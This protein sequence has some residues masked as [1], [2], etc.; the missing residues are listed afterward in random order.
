MPDEPLHPTKK[1]LWDK[2]QE[3]MAKGNDLP[4]SPGLGALLQGAPAGAWDSP[5][6]ALPGATPTADLLSP[7][8][9]PVS[10]AWLPNRTVWAAQPAWVVDS[11]AGDD[12]NDGAT[13][14]T[15][16]K[17]LKE[18][19]RRLYGV[20]LNQYTLITLD[21]D[22]STE[23]L[24][25]L[26][27]VLATGVTLEITGTPTQL[28]AGTITGKTDAVTGVSA[29][30]FTDAA[31]GDITPYIN[32]RARLTGGAQAGKVAWLEY[33]LGATQ[34]Q[35]TQWGNG[36]NKVNATLDTYVIESLTP[37]GGIYVRIAQSGG[38]A[39]GSMLFENLQTV[40]GADQDGDVAFYV[41]S[42]NTVTMIGC[43]L[44]ATFQTI[45][46]VGPYAAYLD[47][48]YL[49]R[50][51]FLGN[52]SLYGC[53]NSIN[54]RINGLNTGGIIYSDWGV[55]RGNVG[56]GNG[57]QLA[58]SSD[59][60]FLPGNEAGGKAIAGFGSQ[61]VQFNGAV[62]GTSAVADGVVVEA[63]AQWMYPNGAKPTLLGS[64][65]NGPKVNGNVLP[66]SAIPIALGQA[67]IYENLQ[68][69]PDALEIDFTF[70]PA[71]TTKAVA[72]PAGTTLN[73]STY[74]VEFVELAPT[75]GTPAPSIGPWS[76]LPSATGF[77]ANITVAPGA[78]VTRNIRARVKL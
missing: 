11:A 69:V 62:W 53:G 8:W 51:A 10:A 73:G 14:A 20:T 4:A 60:G 35:V 5:A 19:G 46:A 56:V 7:I 74:T 27:I 64:T 24:V 68:K 65:G 18:L 31:I 3:A 55:Y 34:A 75:G 25:L 40:D 72:F 1:Q 15:A 61:V 76:V 32:Q 17:T 54:S 78:G 22:F 50:A 71:E 23:N 28:Y 12:N 45:A 26:D 36:H 38:A 48:C 9:D 44:G 41:P 47:Q 2:I 70:G 66:W 6:A 42:Y 21:G 33:K 49:L 29:P 37:V 43:K 30:D 39:D 57:T 52:I 16:L 58:F 63:G 67:A 13:P 77:T 59:N